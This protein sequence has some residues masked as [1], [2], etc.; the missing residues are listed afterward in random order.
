[1]KVLVSECFYIIGVEDDGTEVGITNEEYD[2]A[3]KI[4]NL[5]ADKNNYYVQILK[6][7]PINKNKNI[8]EVLVRENTNNKY[9][10]IKVSYTLE[11]LIHLN[12]AH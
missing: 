9:I 8:Y 3:I 2:E 6:K 12:L 4:L 5:I 10:D 7:T 1:M 11:T